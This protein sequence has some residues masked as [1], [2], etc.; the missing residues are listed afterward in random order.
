[1]DDDGTVSPN[2]SAKAPASA[3]ASAR[4]EALPMLM[5]WALIVYGVTLI[6]TEGKLFAP[7]R[8]LAERRSPWAG[9]LLGCPMCFGWWVGALVSL[10]GWSP[11]A[12]GLGGWPLPLRVLFDG[13]ASSAVCWGL[14]ALVAT[15]LEVRYSLETWRVSR[16]SAT[17]GS[18]V[19][20]GGASTEHPQR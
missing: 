2:P 4:A 18:P 3:T 16:G 9:T 17:H 15:V 11:S 19:T 12:V 1:M 14:G 13:A 10:L 20:I 8:A 5:T 6:V 7:V